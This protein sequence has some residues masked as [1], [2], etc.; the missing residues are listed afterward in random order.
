MWFIVTIL[1][2]VPLLTMG[3]VAELFSMRVVLMFLSLLMAT[4]L[5]WGQKSSWGGVTNHV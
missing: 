2:V 1:P 3:M 5:V 4:I